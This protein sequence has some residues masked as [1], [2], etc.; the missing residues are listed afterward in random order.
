MDSG[1]TLIGP[2]VTETTP[3]IELT[4]EVVAS[5]LSNHQVAAADVPA[6]IRT[7]YGAFTDE[8]EAASAPAVS[9]PTKAQIR[10]SIT[11]DAI[12]SFEDGR[13][14]KMLR[15]HLTTYGLTPA[16]YRAKWGLPSD[17]PI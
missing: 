10:K 2:T 11:A 7:I 3:T 12:I 4:A 16:A 1:R 15:R 17:Y 5:Y 8:P 13:S 6:L 9:G 14:Y